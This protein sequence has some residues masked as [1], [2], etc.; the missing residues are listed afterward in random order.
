[1]KEIAGAKI[2]YGVVDPVVI[3]SNHPKNYRSDVE[4]FVYILSVINGIRRWCEI[5]ATY[6]LIIEFRD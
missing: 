1:M 6:F 3:F 2:N 4:N 5:D